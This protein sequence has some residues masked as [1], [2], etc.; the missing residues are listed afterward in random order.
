MVVEFGEAE[1]L[2]RHVA[3]A[4]GGVARGEVAA[5]DLLQK[6]AQTLAVH[7]GAPRRCG[8]TPT[9]SA[10]QYREPA[11]QVQRGPRSGCAGPGIKPQRP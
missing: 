1:V 9:G 10:H 7:V 2:E 6:I 11:A 8:G 3:E 5:A 4:F